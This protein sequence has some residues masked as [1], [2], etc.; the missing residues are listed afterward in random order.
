M[1][2]PIFLERSLESVQAEKVYLLLRK[3]TSYSMW[4]WGS[5]LKSQTCRVA[6][7]AELT[8][9]KDIVWHIVGAQYITVITIAVNVYIQQVFN[10]FIIMSMRC[11]RNL[12]LYQFV[13]KL[14]L[15]AMHLKL[16][17]LSTR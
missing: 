1:W 17:K 7:R 5:Y 13:V 11:Y 12:F 14:V 16:Q 3:F 4:L 8:V 2:K 6:M 9:F 10:S 15:Y